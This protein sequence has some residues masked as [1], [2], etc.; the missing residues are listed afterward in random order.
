M[1]LDPEG[2][3][4]P[5]EA[6]RRQLIE[7]DLDQRQQVEQGDIVGRRFRRGRTVCGEGAR[8]LCHVSIKLLDPAVHTPEEMAI[9]VSICLQ[10]TKQIVGCGFELGDTP[11]QDDLRLAVS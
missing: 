7:I 11:F 8:R 4:E 9:R 10:G 3:E 6:V 1:D 2:V 5:V